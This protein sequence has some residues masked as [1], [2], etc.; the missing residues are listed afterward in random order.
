M[1]QPFS[2]NPNPLPLENMS[3]IAKARAADYQNATP[4]PHIALDN[5]FD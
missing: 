3:R 2:A 4:F 1:E 5:F